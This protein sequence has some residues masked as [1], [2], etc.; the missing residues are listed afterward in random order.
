MLKFCLAGAMS[1]LAIAAGT[2]AAAENYPNRSLHWIIP[3]AAGGGTDVIARVIAE[4]LSSEFGQPIVVENRPG[5]SSII[6]ATALAQAKPDGYTMLTGD[7][8]TFA[9]N[10]HFYQKMAYDP[11]RDFTYVSLIARFPLLLVARP[12]MEAENGKAFI[13]HLKKN[14]EKLT[15]ATP[16]VGL[17][18]HLATE[19]LLQET[20]T[21]VTHVPYRGSPAALVE[22]NTSRVDFM[23]VDLASGK[24]F[25]ADGR[26]KAYATATEERLP[27]FPDVPTMKELGFDGFEVYAWQGLVVPKGTPD[28][29]VDMLNQSMVKTVGIPEVSTRMRD[30]GVEPITS[31][32]E[33][34]AAYVAEESERWGELIRARGLKID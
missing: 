9:T 6:G 21:K 1:A 19:L 18:H 23:F 29:V 13:E 14:D 7:N 22:L 30:I 4:R 31:T 24:S 10:P 27:E 11:D 33:A 5:A 25:I 28:N 32:P 3:N 2:V 26:V 8:A 34:F 16:G 20:G 17:P 15:Y 12:D